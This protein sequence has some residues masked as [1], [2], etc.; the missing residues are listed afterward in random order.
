MDIVVENGKFVALSRFNNPAH[1]MFYRYKFGLRY[2]PQNSYDWSSST[3][4]CYDMY[5]AIANDASFTSVAP[6]SLSASGMGSVAVSYVGTYNEPGYNSLNGHA[7]TC[8]VGSEG[9]STI[10]TSYNKSTTEMSP[11]C[12]YTD[13]YHIESGSYTSGAFSQFKAAISSTTYNTPCTNGIHN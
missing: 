6:I 11:Q 3:L 5:D 8:I 9:A 13:N 2:L 10:R 1:F 7:I 12:M 4:Y